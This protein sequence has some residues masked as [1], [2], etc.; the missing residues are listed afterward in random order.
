[1]KDKIYNLVN[2]KSIDISNLKIDLKYAT[3]DNFTQQIIYP[4]IANAYLVEVA[5]EA[6]K[7][8]ARE[9]NALGYTIKIWDAYRP[10][11]AQYI[12]WNL[13]SDERYVAD[14]SKGSRHNRGCAIDVTLMDN[15]GKELDM[16]TE[17]D[18]FSP[19]AHRD[20]T[21]LSLEVIQNRQLLQNIMEKHSF[22]GWKNEWWHFDFKDWDR[23][24]ILD[25]SF[26]ELKNAHCF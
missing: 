23:Y 16:G 4:S 7:S 12:F 2:L 1:M 8:V 3:Q 25:I 24:P 11:S 20:F 5:A 26:E 10:L 14:P 6:L 13:V 17:F 15:N 18:D 19:K 22:I 9:L 21:E